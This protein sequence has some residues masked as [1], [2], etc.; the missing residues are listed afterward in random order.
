MPQ[1]ATI[2]PL[3]DRLR[4]AVLQ[5]D[6]DQSDVARLL[7]TNPRT[8]SRWLADQTEPRPDA[9]RRLLEVV[10]VLEHL[11]GVLK[12]QAAHD[13]LFSPNPMLDHHKPVDLLAEGDFRRVLALIDALA[14]GVFV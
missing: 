8:V 14:E 2:E 1:R 10:A 9:R 12:P 5:T 11:S 3:P 4:R 6:L 13:W 7:G